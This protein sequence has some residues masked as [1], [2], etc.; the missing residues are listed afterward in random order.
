MSNGILRLLWTDYHEPVNLGN[1]CEFT[2]LELAQRIC[3]MVGAECP[4]IFQPAM[5]DDPKVR[6][7]DITRARTLLDWQP[8]VELA[9]GLAWTIAAF[10]EALDNG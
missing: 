8:E 6:R 9:Q 7:P 1:P 4:I 3:E 5:Q 2:M 10:R